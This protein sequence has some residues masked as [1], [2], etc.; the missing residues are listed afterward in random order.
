MF[1]VAMGHVR[2]FGHAAVALK[3]AALT[4]KE[5]T[6]AVYNELA[7]LALCAGHPSIPAVRRA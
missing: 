1:R 3:A 7:M 2:G 4:S 5:A 6:M